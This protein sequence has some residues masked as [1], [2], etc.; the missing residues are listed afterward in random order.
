MAPPSE[1]TTICSSL[2]CILV[3]R[4][5]IAVVKCNFNLKAVFHF[6]TLFCSERQTYLFHF[7]HFLL[8]EQ[9]SPHFKNSC[10]G[11]FVNCH[12]SKLLRQYLARLRISA[13]NATGLP[14]DS[15]RAADQT[16]AQ[17]KQPAGEA[18]LLRPA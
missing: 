2:I 18:T 14:L 8:S 11:E 9:D 6:H 4:R 12:I 10:F 16:A 5:T 13:N 17:A 3:F 1:V 15:N 7:V